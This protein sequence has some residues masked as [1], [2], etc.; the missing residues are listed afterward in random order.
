VQHV[1]KLFKAATAIVLFGRL[2]ALLFGL[3]PLHVVLKLLIVVTE[4]IPRTGSPV[5]P[6]GLLLRMLG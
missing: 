1:D 5:L 6:L 4:V 2:L 3:P